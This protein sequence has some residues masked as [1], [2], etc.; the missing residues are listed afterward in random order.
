[1]NHYEI[2][3]I[4][5]KEFNIPKEQVENI[6]TDFWNGIKYY[7]ENP[8][9]SFR[10]GVMIKGLITFELRSKYWFEKKIGGLLSDVVKYRGKERSKTEKELV[11]AKIEAARMQKILNQINYG[12]HSQ[13]KG[14]HED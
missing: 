12:K 7:L 3:K 1:M 6:I 5:S 10:K 14:S 8:I 2:V 9:G 11:T 4:L 13:G